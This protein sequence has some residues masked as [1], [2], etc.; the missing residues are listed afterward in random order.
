MQLFKSKKG[1][2]SIPV[3]LPKVPTSLLKSSS[4]NLLTFFVLATLA[5]Q[6]LL[7]IQT[8]LNT[9]WIAKLNNR[10]APTLVEL[11]DGRSIQV[12]SND[13]QYRSPQ[14]I[15]NFTSEIVTMLFSTPGKLSLEPNRGSNRIDPGVVLQGRSFHTNNKVT[16]AAWQASFALSEDF[17]SAFLAELAQ[18]TSPGVFAGIN[19][20]VLSI[21][22]LSQPQQIEAGKWKLNMIANLYLFGAGDKVG[23]VIPVN[24]TIYLQAVYVNPQPLAQNA[25]DMQR[26]IY[27]ARSAGLEIS[28]FGDLSAPVNSSLKSH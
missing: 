8:T 22:Y 12:G 10:P 21:N 4:G 13:W 24:K 11:Q 3:K 28:R 9:I 14:A 2:D 16:T 17:R 6:F 7:F 15:L 25:S 1:I 20:T 5:L 27:R 26:L 23:Q 18:I 19:Q